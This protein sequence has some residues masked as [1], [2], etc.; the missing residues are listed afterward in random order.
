ML[1]HLYFKTVMEG[2]TVLI[3]CIWRGMSIQHSVVLSPS[4]KKMAF[5]AR[6]SVEK[7]WFTVLINTM[8]IH[9]V[10]SSVLSWSMSRFKSHHRRW[11]RTPYTYQSGGRFKPRTKPVLCSKRDLPLCYKITSWHSQ[12]NNKNVCALPVYNIREHIT[13][14]CI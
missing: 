14:T 9:R 5:L 4:K 6:V 7:Y 2:T 3:V 13:I 12:R 1:I 11:N 8:Y 10:H